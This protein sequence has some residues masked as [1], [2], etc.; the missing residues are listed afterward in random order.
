MV[1]VVRYGVTMI[2]RVSFN[3]IE[4]ECDDDIRVSI[5]VMPG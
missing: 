3:V 4:D 2:L 5:T 1:L